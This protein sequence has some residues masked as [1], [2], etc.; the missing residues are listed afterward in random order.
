VLHS[1]YS[2]LPS[3][4]PS[5]QGELFYGVKGCVPAFN[6]MD[7]KL[8]Q[9]VKMFD[10]QYVEQFEPRLAEQGE[11]L[12]KGGSAY[13]NIYTGGAQEAHFCAVHLGIGRVFH[14]KNFFVFAIL[15]ILYIDIFI[16]T[17][18]LLTIEFFLALYDSIR[19]MI[20]RKI[21]YKE[22][23]MIWLRV[24]VCIFLRELIVAG[25]CMDIARGLPIIHMNFLGYDE[26]SHCRGPSSR[27][28]HWSLQGIDHAIRRIDHAIKHSS[29]REYD[30]WI[31][32][33]HGQEKTVP[34]LIEH[35]LTIK[36][37]VQKLFG[38]SKITC[39]LSALKEKQSSRAKL[40]YKSKKKI[41][42]SIFPSVDAETIMVTAMGPLGHIYVNKKMDDEE[43][44][45]YAHKL[46]SE[47]KIPLVLIRQEQEKILAF[48]AQGTFSLPEQIADVIGEDHPF[49]E[50]MKEDII[51]ICKH[52]N[53]G[54][55]VIAGWSKGMTPISFPME[56]GGHAGFTKEETNS[57]ALL[58]MDAPV[59]TGKIY[60]RPT[61]L[62][63]AALQFLNRGSITQSS[64]S[65]DK[66]QITSTKI[67]VET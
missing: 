50:D 34:Y 24:L 14:S 39:E 37:A 5:V 4:T 54:D 53:A 22:I 55:F 17:F 15:I 61:D 41:I 56:F 6:F 10:A 60:L 7:R 52:H 33:D 43:K 16:R 28:A 13:S 11:G 49:L 23:E 3:N 29:H 57:F 8:A 30:L 31:Y 44:N 66:V 20:K 18:I 47:V 35:G 48:T 51:R 38:S 59:Q 63:E 67:K 45:F 1:L 40:L 9:S 27:F 65:D 19:G 32:G 25:A 12:L 36:E 26:Q 64:F 21:F 2:G 58:P 42:E 62:R 46:V